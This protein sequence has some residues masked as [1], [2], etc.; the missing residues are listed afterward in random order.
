MEINMFFLVLLYLIVRHPMTCWWGEDRIAS[1]ITLVYLNFEDVSRLRVRT[2]GKRV[3]FEDITVDLDTSNLLVPDGSPPQSSGPI[4]N[5]GRSSSSG[6]C[7]AAVDFLSFGADV[8]LSSS[9]TAEPPK[10]RSKSTV[11]NPVTKNAQEVARDLQEQDTLGPGPS[12]MKLR[13]Y[14]TD[15][16]GMLDDDECDEI[17]A[18]LKSEHVDDASTSTHSAMIVHGGDSDL[19]RVALSVATANFSSWNQYVWIVIMSHVI[20]IRLHAQI[21]NEKKITLALWHKL[22]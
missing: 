4:A 7:D 15:F 1:K 17:D 18:I 12:D 6:A 2:L 3:G 14:V 8:V 10:K 20:R 11:T 9:S 13:H 16:D 21:Q 5:G 19:P 22:L